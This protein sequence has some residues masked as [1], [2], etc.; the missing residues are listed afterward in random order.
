MISFYTLS[1]IWEGF[2]KIQK[3]DVDLHSK[4]LQLQKLVRHYIKKKESRT[5]FSK[6]SSV[7]TKIICRLDHSLVLQGC[8]FSQIL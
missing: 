3:N 8:S 1:K 4:H 5:L 7:A 2:L 6:G